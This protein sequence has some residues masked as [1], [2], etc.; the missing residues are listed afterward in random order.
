MKSYKVRVRATHYCV[1]QC[2]CECVYVYDCTCR[3]HVATEAMST[4][5]LTCRGLT[6]PVCV[7]GIEAFNLIFVQV[8]FSYLSKVLA[9]CVCVCVSVFALS[10]ELNSALLVAL[11]LSCCCFCFCFWP[12]ARCALMSE[13]THILITAG[14]KLY[15]K[16]KHKGKP[17]HSF[18][19]RSA[20][21]SSYIEG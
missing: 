18:K 21:S 10:S 19:I 3:W 17:E 9:L 13:P 15:T 16:K 5:N 7:W 12:A 14:P 20:W 6:R 1:R 8:R 2:V 11:N 4:L